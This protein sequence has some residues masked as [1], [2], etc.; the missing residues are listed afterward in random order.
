MVV[1]EGIKKKKLKLKPRRLTEGK[2]HSTV[3]LLYDLFG[4]DQTSKIVVHSTKAKQLIAN[5][6]NRRSAVQ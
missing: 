5:N 6:L 2:Y 3:D 1:V 4:I